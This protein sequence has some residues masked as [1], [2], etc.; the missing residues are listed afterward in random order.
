VTL[1]SVVRGRTLSD[2]VDAVRTNSDVAAQLR[3]LLRRSRK[4]SFDHYHNLAK[5]LLARHHGR[6]FLLLVDAMERHS[7]LKA[8]Q[9]ERIR[10]L[11]RE[12]PRP[13]ALAEAEAASRLPEPPAS[14]AVPEGGPGAQP[15]HAALGQTA[16]AHPPALAARTGLPR[17]AGSGRA[18]V[19]PAGASGWGWLA[20]LWASARRKD[21]AG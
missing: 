11:G 17:F 4:S 10:E 2:I 15:G 14:P 5:E 13:P 8:A 1:R 21:R 18:A 20:R 19:S 3:L 7:Q 6:M 16:G 12:T 9:M